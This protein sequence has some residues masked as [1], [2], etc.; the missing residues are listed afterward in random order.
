MASAR[1]PNGSKANGFKANGI[2]RIRSSG[3]LLCSGSA[4]SVILVRR[5]QCLVIITLAGTAFPVSNGSSSS[6]DNEH[7]IVGG[8][9]TGGVERTM[10]LYR[11]W[12]RAYGLD[13]DSPLPPAN[14][15]LPR[16][17]PPA[18]HLEDC[19]E[20]TAGRL[21]LE[22]RGAQGEA[23]A[24]AR[25]GEKCNC[26]PHPPWVRGT[27]SENL[28]AT[29]EA[30]RDMWEHQ[31]PPGACSGQKLLVVPW[32]FPLKHGVGSQIHIMSAFLSI[33]MAHKRVLVPDPGNY[34]RAD[35]EACKAQGQEGSWAC[36][37]LPIVSLACEQRVQAAKEAGGMACARD[38]VKER[39]ASNEDIV[40]VGDVPYNELDHEASIVSK[41]GTPHLQRPDTVWHVVSPR[42]VDP[43]NAPVHWWRAQSARFMLREPSLHLCH[44][45]NQQRHVAFGMRA[46]SRLANFLETS[47]K[48]LRVVAAATA[49]DAAY[50]KITLSPMARAL[51]LSTFTPADIDAHVNV[52]WAYDSCNA[53]C[54][55]A[56]A[57]TAATAAVATAAASATAAAAD[58][59][60]G[61]Y[62]LWLRG[63]YAQVGGEPYVVRPLLGM[64][65]RHS[66]MHVGEEME[67]LP[68]GVHMYFAQQL[69]L[70]QVDLRHV[71]LNTEA[72]SVIDETN[73]Y[74]EWTFFYGSNQRQ[75]EASMEKHDYEKSQSVASSLAS[76]LIAAQSDYFIGVLGS[77]W[78]RLMNELRCTNGRLFSSFIALNDDNL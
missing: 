41:W 20:R 76:L 69:R 50:H 78:S 72:Q 54:L 36:Y 23:P 29:R 13:S 22:E 1:A 47:D 2:S 73:N 9:A 38:R 11:A 56:A 30:Q 64:H 44:V 52:P 39:A 37:F 21:R 61:G 31:F 60:L 65:V 59:A 49:G 12:Q 45:S 17:V 70:V 16:N 27:D 62:A 28:A 19:A 8:D 3:G 67:V 43:R 32:A 14:V 33:A 57:A 75:S 68:L 48:T 53:S 63:M 42:S 66:E 51:S 10:A 74:K 46:A 5:F 4:C 15:S 25:P 7:R 18:P 77:N 58:A 55:G 34:S 35:S 40:C 71:W 26:A 24:W 6:S